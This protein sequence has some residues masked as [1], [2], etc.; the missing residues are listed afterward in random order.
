MGTCPADQSPTNF[1]SVVGTASDTLLS[2]LNEADTEVSAAIGERA[3]R[4]ATLRCFSVLVSGRQ[5]VAAGTYVRDVSTV[6]LSTDIADRPLAI[7][8]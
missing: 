4:R 5:P 6:V 7:S 8:S 1:M 2:R 3:R